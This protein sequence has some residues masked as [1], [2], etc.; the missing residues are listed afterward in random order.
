MKRRS[1]FTLVELLVVI[2]IIG[3]LVAL[4]L[5]AVQSAREAARRT[6][7]VNSMK[8][9]ALACINF[10]S[11]KTYLP[12]G[13]PS[14]VA[15]QP[16]GPKPVWFVAGT[17]A[18]GECYGP[19]WAAQLLNYL[20]EGAAANLAA[21]ALKNFPEDA[22]EANPM[23]NWDLKR[24]EFGG[25][26]ARI[27]KS[28]LCP[29]SASESE[30]LLYNDEDEG[31]SGMGL[32][33]LSKTNRVACFGSGT[34]QDATP[35]RTPATALFPNIKPQNSGLFGIELIKKFPVAS[36]VG[37]GI[38]VAKAT[39]GLSKTVMLSEVLVWKETNKT[40]DT[41]SA[42]YS[43][44]DDW[45]GTWMIPSMGASAFSGFYPPNVRPGS[46]SEQ[47]ALDLIPACGTEIGNQSSADFS[48]LP[49]KE[50]KD[51]GQ[52]Y[53]S[54]RSAHPGG[55]NAAL[56]DASVRFVNDDVDRVV[57]QAACSRAGDDIAGDF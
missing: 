39:D 26:G 27:H 2:A 16:T 8:Q 10:E 14:C 18:G 22:D 54:A 37:K 7:C 57:W 52:T 43:G 12:P 38:R 19:N 49:C 31:T 47:N 23:D 33:F 48:Q 51:S 4:L 17:Q 1:G 28:F 11:A 6:S 32:A 41:G 53:A 25:F 5:P 40:E 9:D 29:S 45:R 21:E 3:I 36:R 24:G 42:S 15:S 30:Q 34:M 13:G 55:V 20:E 46:G 56:G 50:L 44:N 35:V